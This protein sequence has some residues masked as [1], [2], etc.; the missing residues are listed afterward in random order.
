MSHKKTFNP[1]TLRKAVWDDKE[2]NVMFEAEREQHLLAF[3]STL[4]LLA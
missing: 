2:E 1:E 4:L 3:A